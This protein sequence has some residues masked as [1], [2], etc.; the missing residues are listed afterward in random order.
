[1]LVFYTCTY[2]LVGCSFYIN[3]SLCIGSS[4]KQSQEVIGSSSLNYKQQV[5]RFFQENGID[6]NYDYPYD[7]TNGFR[8]IVRY[9]L[10]GVN[11]EVDSK[12]YYS[13]K[14][15]A[16]EQVAKLVLSKEKVSQVVSKGSTPPSKVWKSKL[17]EYCDKRRASV[18]MMPSYETRQSKN[19][20]QSRVNFMGQIIEGEEC[21]SKQEAEQNAAQ[22]ALRSV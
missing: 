15:E 11:K 20:F 3:H 2:L 12:N 17:K 19:G 8:C 22:H 14:T 1:M 13:S 16:K 4:P 9:Q 5:N 21:K 18:D 10:C 7:L 6:P